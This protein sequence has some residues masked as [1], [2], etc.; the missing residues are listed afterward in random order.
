MK[1]NKAIFIAILIPFVSVVIASI[2][3]YAS[4]SNSSK[5][6][7]STS[8]PVERYVNSPKSFAGNSYDIS[9]SVESQLAYADDKG[10]LL[11]LKT[12]SGKS[13]PIFVPKTINGFNP[14]TGQRYNFETRIDQ[15]GK[16][17]MTNFRKL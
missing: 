3:L 2:F 13:L 6:N 11:L 10:R 15:S 14:N 16:L 12:F 17:I 5:L 9:A 8:L 1:K 7:D 4:K